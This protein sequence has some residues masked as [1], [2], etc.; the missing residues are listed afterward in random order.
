LSP[1]FQSLKLITLK[2]PSSQSKKNG[3]QK[4]QLVQAALEPFK[5]ETLLALQ[6]QQKFQTFAVQVAKNRK[7]LSF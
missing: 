5:R 2:R 3:H 6:T 1:T 4:D 7:P